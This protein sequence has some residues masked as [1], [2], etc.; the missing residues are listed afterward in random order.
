MQILLLFHAGAI[1]EKLPSAHAEKL[2]FAAPQ[3]LNEYAFLCICGDSTDNEF[4]F[5]N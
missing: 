3:K 4:E 2:S 1:G 5:A